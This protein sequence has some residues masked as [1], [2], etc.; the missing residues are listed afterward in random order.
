[1]V[2]Q[3]DWHMFTAPIRE[4]CTRNIFITVHWNYLSPELRVQLCG[5]GT[6][7]FPHRVRALMGEG[8]INESNKYLAKDI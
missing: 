2:L 5:L 7:V 8:K 4:Y 3:I 6:E 1:M